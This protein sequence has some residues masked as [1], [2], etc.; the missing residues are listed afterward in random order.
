MTGAAVRCS[1]YLSVRLSVCRFHDLEF[2]RGH[3]RAGE[4]SFGLSHASPRD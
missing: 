4:A 2:G 3:Y 1:I